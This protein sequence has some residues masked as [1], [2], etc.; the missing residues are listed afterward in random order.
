M[1]RNWKLE[2]MLN[3]SQH[4][5]WT[6]VSHRPCGHSILTWVLRIQPQSH[7]WRC[8]RICVEI[9]QKPAANCFDWRIYWA[10]FPMTWNFQTSNLARLIRHFLSRL[11]FLTD[12]EWTQ[13]LATSRAGLES[14]RGTAQERKRTTMRNWRSYRL[15]G[16]AWLY[17][18][19]WTAWVCLST[20]AWAPFSWQMIF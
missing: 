7:G 19:C 16:S 3:I 2:E 5:R 18:T 8:T 1:N 14:S 15:T 11:V 10:P 9:V 13:T 6:P 20:A 17:P 12:S 4:T